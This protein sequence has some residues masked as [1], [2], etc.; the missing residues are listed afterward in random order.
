MK[1][2]ILLTVIVLLACVNV[3]FSQASPPLGN[4]PERVEWLRDLGFGMFIHWNVDGTL[5]GVIS[6]SMV[7]AS[8]DYLQRYVNELPKLFN[9]Y[10][11]KPDDWAML[12]KLAGMKYVV[13][14]TKHHA[15]F[16]MWDSKTTSFNSMNTPYGKDITKQLVAAFRQQG[17]AVGFYF[18]PD[19]FLWLWKNGKPVARAPH[20]GVTPQENK[21]LME[22]DKAQIKELLTNYGPIDFFFI[23][24]PA[25]SLREYCWELQPNIVVTRGAIATPEQYIPGLPLEGA[26]EANLTMGT[27]WP[28]KPTNETYKSGQDLIRTLIETRAKGGNLLLNVGPKPDGEL[29]IQQ[30]D[31][32]REVALWMFVNQESIHGTRPWSVTNEGGIWFTRK[33]DTVYAIVTDAWKY[34]DPKTMTLKTVAATKDSVVSVL[35]QTGEILEYR[36]QVVP[37]AKWEQTADGLTITAYKAQR[38]YTNNQWPNPVVLKITNAKSIFEPPQ[39]VTLTGSRNADK[40]SATL[41][42]RLDHLGK[43]PSVE[44]SF[45]YRVKPEATEFTDRKWIDTEKILRTVTG[46]FSATISGLERNNE[47]E[48]RAIVKH[49][50]ITLTG[51][52]VVV[53]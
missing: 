11:Y 32:L 12:A 2:R 23:D 28:Y 3:S 39:I 53:P 16:C 18:S 38:L 25:E 43:A 21:A 20:P 1:T 8:E 4:K 48:F 44:V 45:Q 49:P 24:G 14:T 36:P 52:E 7:G 40:T 50:L 10:K 5:G 9:P 47:Y 6:H 13:F 30:E 37:R 41:R 51:K 46:E 34:G 42:G 26:W 31:R 27:E 19:D 35:G 22:Y 29:P 17:I 33:G 15:G